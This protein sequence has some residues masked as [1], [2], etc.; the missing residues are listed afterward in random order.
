MRFIQNYVY[1]VLVLDVFI[2]IQNRESSAVYVHVFLWTYISPRM[3]HIHTYLPI[4]IITVDRHAVW[5]RFIGKSCISCKTIFT[6][7]L[8]LAVA[9]IVIFPIAIPMI[10]HTKHTLQ[11]THSLQ[12]TVN[13]NISFTD[14]FHCFITYLMICLYLSWVSY[15][16]F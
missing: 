2:D 12:I 14:C 3:D 1:F 9:A 15:V 5:S 13:W 11:E 7:I 4:N 8:R 6:R 16:T 10:E